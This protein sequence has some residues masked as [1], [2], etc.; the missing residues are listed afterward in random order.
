MCRGG[1]TRVPVAARCSTAPGEHPARSLRKV[2]RE[3]LGFLH[4]LVAGM[5]PPGLF[6]EHLWPPLSW[7][8]AAADGSDA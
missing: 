6:T 4:L 1:T 7:P 2:L 8:R 3:D 5:R